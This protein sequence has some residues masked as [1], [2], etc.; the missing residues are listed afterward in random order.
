M[1]FFSPQ[2]PSSL[3]HP[4]QRS[5]FL[6]CV[7]VFIEEPGIIDM[8]ATSLKLNNVDMGLDFSPSLL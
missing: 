4:T 8:D 2:P 6:L 5:L 1:A 7:I 3:A